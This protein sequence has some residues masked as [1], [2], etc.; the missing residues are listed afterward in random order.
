MH[1]RHFHKV[2]VVSQQQSVGVGPPAEAGRWAVVPAAVVKVVW[3]LAEICINTVW[4]TSADAILFFL[5]FLIFYIL[6][7]S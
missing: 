4:L 1:L 7:F 3:R 2:P 5:F 6:F